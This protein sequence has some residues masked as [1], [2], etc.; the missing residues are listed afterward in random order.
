MAKRWLVL[1]FILLLGRS[2]FAGV[3]FEVETKIHQPS[4]EI[5]THQISVE[6]RDL[7]MERTS[8]EGAP[9]NT[10]IYHGD[11]REMV[12]IDHDQKRYFVI[13][14]Q[15]LQSMA[16]RQKQAMSQMQQMLKN[17]PENQR[18]MIEK[19][20]KQRMGQMPAQQPEPPEHELRKTDSRAVKAGYPCQ[21]YE[22]W[23]AGRK[24]QELWVT[25]W[26]NVNG[27]REAKPALK[28]MAEF[29]HDM[30][31]SFANAS[32]MPGAGDG[33]RGN[34]LMNVMQQ[35]DGFPVITLSFRD[36][37]LTEETVLRSSRPQTLP[38]A[39]FAPPA[40]YT[41]RQMFGK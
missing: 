15:A 27:G 36:D 10:M 26:R 35:I 23:Q 9:S 34:S 20:M 21:K 41:P 24:I 3:V 7:R 37:V 14:R 12:L 32:G 13:D 22:I 2:G 29:S 8:G 39:A 25:D 6:G 16:E 18:A 1:V 30:Q 31:Q 28:E 17:V 40:G 38:P 5:M 11:Q 4:P 19:M 33:R